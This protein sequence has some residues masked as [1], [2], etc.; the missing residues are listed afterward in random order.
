MRHIHVGELVKGLGQQA[1]TGQS[2]R[3]IPSTLRVADSQAREAA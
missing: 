3:R 1:E 2:A